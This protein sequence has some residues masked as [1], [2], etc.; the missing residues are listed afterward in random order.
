MM[1]S[2][3]CCRVTDVV[4]QHTMSSNRRCWVTG[5]SASSITSTSTSTSTLVL[6]LLVLL[7]LD[8]IS[9]HFRVSICIRT[10]LA[11]AMIWA[12]YAS[13]L[14]VFDIVLGGCR[15]SLEVHIYV[16]YAGESFVYLYMLT[17]FYHV[18]WWCV[19]MFLTMCDHCLLVICAHGFTDVL[20]CF[21]DDVWPCFL[22][23]V[24]HVFCRLFDLNT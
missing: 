20:Q 17:M 21:V 2:N 23:I 13:V 14:H 9:R 1:L 5:V 22:T 15:S 10:L 19:T 7:V 16:E 6:A 3:R 12:W 8:L 24:D 18:F 11:L 4:E